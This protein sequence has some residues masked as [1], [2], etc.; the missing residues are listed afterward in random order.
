MVTEVTEVTYINICMGVLKPPTYIVIK[1]R[2]MP[3]VGE[4]L[5]PCPTGAHLIPDGHGHTPMGCPG[6]RLEALQKITVCLRLSRPVSAPV[7]LCA[8][9]GL[10]WREIPTLKFA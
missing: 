9:K 6:V 7:T 1:E 8:F 3:Q 10:G 2:Q 5:T 4:T